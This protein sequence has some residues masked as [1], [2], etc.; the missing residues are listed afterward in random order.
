MKDLIARR[1]LVTG[2]TGGIGR[3]IALELHHQGC[4]LI[5]TGR[6]VER[7]NNV[8]KEVEGLAMPADLADRGQLTDLLARAGEIDILIANAAVPASGE[9]DEWEQDQIDRALEVNLASPIAMTRALLPSFRQRNSGHF[10]FVSSLAGKVGSR[11][12]SLYSATKFGL[13]GFAGGL[14]CDLYGSGV[15]CSVVFPGFVRDAG[16]FADTRATLLPGV[17]T[18]TPGQVAKA[19]VRA[20]K[21]NRAELDVAPLPLRWGARIG[22]ITPGLSAVVQAKVGRGISEQLVEAQRTKR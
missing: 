2:A 19:V 8:A 12:G 11:G 4:Q 7:L 3:A 18:V 13:R 20:I 9:L 22:S 5:V 15:G 6:R 1:A 14:R 16:M 17:R 21:S 10:V